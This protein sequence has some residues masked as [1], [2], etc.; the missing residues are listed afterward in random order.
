MPKRHLIPG[1]SLPEEIKGQYIY[2]GNSMHPVFKPGQLLYVR[3]ILDEPC[4]GDIIVFF[5]PQ[6]K[7]HVVHRVIKVE[8]GQIHT[9]GDN[10]PS[11][12]QNTVNPKD[13][14]G[15]VVKADQ[16]GTITKVW[17]GKA[18]YHRSKFQIFTKGLINFLKKL[19]Y[20]IYK[21]I[22]SVRI[23]PKIWHPEIQKVQLKTPAGEV[24]KYIH[25]G[26]TVAQWN[27]ASKRFTYK[28]PYDLVIN[29]PE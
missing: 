7:I 25:Q 3:P 8:N 13:I 14:I 18:G 28:H 20:P 24:I 6:S 10:N 27:S 17:G 11:E 12:D 9:R 21:I 1:S 4:V 19:V 5:D 16:A 23:V 2:T 26:K 29:P 22:K 15:V